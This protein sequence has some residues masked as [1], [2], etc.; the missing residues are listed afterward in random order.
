MGLIDTHTHLESFA[1]K[2]TLADALARAKEFGL[3]AMVTIGTSPDDWSLYRELARKNPG[4]V[5]YAVGV[6][7][8]SVDERWSEAVAQ[9]EGFWDCHLLNDKPPV[10]LGE[11]GLDRFHL[12]KDNVAEAEKI[13]R[14]QRAAFAAQ[15]EITRRLGCPLVVHSR[16]AFRECVRCHLGVFGARDGHCAN[17]VRAELARE[18]C[19]RCA[20]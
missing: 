6:H 8:C 13:F 9:I 10:A 17:R 15:L 11:T 4:F 3:E 18:L 5:H 16:G 12:P 19:S 14:W 1:H 7:P 20:S 2:G